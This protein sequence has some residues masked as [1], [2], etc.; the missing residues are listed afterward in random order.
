MH[1]LSFLFIALFIT[2][3]TGAQNIRVAVGKKCK[4]VAE[5]KAISGTSVMGQ[6]VD[7]SITGK[8]IAEVEIKTVGPN[9]Y[10][11][12]STLKRI[13]SSVNVMGREQN[14]DSD[15]ALLNSQLN[16]WLKIFYK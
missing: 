12:V 10:T 11:L 2:C 14:F 5:T 1:R 9:G 16:V 8:S 15:N 6:Q 3:V 13:M 7:A 4:V